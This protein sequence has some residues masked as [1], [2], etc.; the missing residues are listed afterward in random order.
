MFPSGIDAR[1]EF[2]Q[3][4]G[5]STL[6]AR[7]GRELTR[8]I[9]RRAAIVAVGPSTARGQGVPG[10]VDALRVALDRLPLAHFSKSRA[11]S[12]A[13]VLDES[14]QQVVAGLPRPARSWGLARKC[15]NIFLRDCFY[16]AYLRDAY[17]LTVAEPWFEVPLDRVVAE[18]LR[19]HLPNTLPRWPGVKRVTPELSEHFQEKASVLSERWRITRVHLDTYLWVAGR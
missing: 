12:F 2:V 4:S 19:S 16:N 8:A 1:G 6:E 5:R 17:G 7:V 10:V 18:G 13:R 11:G 15:L 14:T 9:K 3:E